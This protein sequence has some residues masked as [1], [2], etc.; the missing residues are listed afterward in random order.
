M[1]NDNDGEEKTRSRRIIELAR[2][3]LYRRTVEGRPYRRNTVVDT[4]SAES[5]PLG[6]DSGGGSGCR[7]HASASCTAVVGGPKAL[8]L[9]FSRSGPYTVYIIILLSR[10]IPSAVSRPQWPYSTPPPPRCCGICIFFSVFPRNVSPRT[11]F[12]ALRLVS[13]LYYYY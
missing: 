4:D 12:P 11:L 2:A 13:S 1:V 9:L 6:G 5:S 10:T 7:E 8:P 3:H